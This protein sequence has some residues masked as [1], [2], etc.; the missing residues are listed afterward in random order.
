MVETDSARPTGNITDSAAAYQTGSTIA[1]DSDAVNG[2]TED[3]SGNDERTSTAFHSPN[4]SDTETVDIYTA[5]RIDQAAFP[6]LD[7]AYEA[8]ASGHQ[9]NTSQNEHPEGSASGRV[10]NFTRIVVTAIPRS[11]P[12]NSSIEVRWREANGYTEEHWLTIPL[13]YESGQNGYAIIRSVLR[14]SPVD[15]SPDQLAENCVRLVINSMPFDSDGGSGNVTDK[16]I[17]NDDPIVYEIVARG[18]DFHPLLLNH[19]NFPPD[20][21]IEEMIEVLLDAIYGFVMSLAQ[22]H[23]F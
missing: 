5:R 2:E 19:F 22:V 9:Q 16:S 6:D 7:T 20:P 4:V 18:A 11:N 8:A 23:E 21:V 10:C 14:Q 3:A 17:P 12:Y 1:Q 13:R 15:F